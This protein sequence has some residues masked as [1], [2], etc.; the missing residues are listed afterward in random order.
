VWPTLLVFA[1]LSVIIFYGGRLLLQ[2][3]SGTGRTASPAEL[4]VLG[5]G[6]FWLALF[7]NNR[8]T[9]PKSLGFDVTGHLAYV[10]FIKTH[11]ALS[12]ASDGW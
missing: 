9:L 3:T 4:A 10:E 8:S 5:L 1:A 12:L 2:K 6:I 11:H 7:I